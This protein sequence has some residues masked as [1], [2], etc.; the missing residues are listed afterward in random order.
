MFIDIILNLFSIFFLQKFVSY[1][2]D[3][4]F[5]AYKNNC[6][7]VI[8]LRLDLCVGILLWSNLWFQSKSQKTKTSDFGFSSKTLLYV[9]NIKTL[10]YVSAFR[11]RTVWNFVIS[12]LKNVC[13]RSRTLFSPKPLKL[14]IALCI[15]NFH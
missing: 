3:I 5:I 14:Q 7:M 11:K 6:Y 9:K 8:Y 13:L 1:E 15:T 2:N 10:Y 12:W 4:F